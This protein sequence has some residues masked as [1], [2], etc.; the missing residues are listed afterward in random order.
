[1]K[2]SPRAR[3]DVLIERDALRCQNRALNAGSSVAGDVA[4]YLRPAFVL[5]P[6]FCHETFKT[7]I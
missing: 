5:P 7:T 1:M 6:D 4:T 2:E 3:T